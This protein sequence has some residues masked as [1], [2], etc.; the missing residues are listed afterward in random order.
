MSSCITPQY[1]FKTK[2]LM[3]IGGF[4]SIPPTT[5]GT[6]KGVKLLQFLAVAQLVVMMLDLIVVPHGTSPEF[7][8]YFGVFFELFYVFILYQAWAGLNHCSCVI[9]VLICLYQV[10]LLF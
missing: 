9:Y 1:I 6:K 3:C 5:P 4:Q 7:G 8:S 10:T 2:K